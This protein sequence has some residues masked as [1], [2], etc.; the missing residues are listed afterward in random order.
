[1]MDGEIVSPASASIVCGDSARVRATSV[2]I[3]AM[4]PF[5]RSRSTGS[6]M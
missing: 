4:P 2:A 6:R 1:M 3:R 5:W